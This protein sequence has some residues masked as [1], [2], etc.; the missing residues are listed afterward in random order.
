MKKWRMLYELGVNLVMM[1]LADEQIKAAFEQSEKEVTDLHSRI[2]EVKKNGTQ[3]VSLRVLS[4]LLKNLSIAKPSSKSIPK[5][6]VEVS[7]IPM[8]LSSAV[9]REIAIIYKRELKHARYN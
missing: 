9:A 5:T 6:L 4:S 3:I 7:M 1:A 8:S 2:R